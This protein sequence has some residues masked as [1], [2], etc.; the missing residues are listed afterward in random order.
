MIGLCHSCLTSGIEIG[1]VKGKIICD[2][3]ILSGVKSIV[4][5]PDLEERLA[6]SELPQAHP[7]EVARLSYK[8]SEESFER[9]M[10]RRIQNNV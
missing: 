4:K 6:F 3:C 2:N 8:F 9:I 10:K 1:V 7:D 5:Q